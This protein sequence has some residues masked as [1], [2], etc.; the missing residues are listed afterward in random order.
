M[1]CCSRLCFCQNDPPLL[2]GPKDPVLPSLM[3]LNPTQYGL[4]EVC[5]VYNEG[6]FGYLYPMLGSVL[7]VLCGVYLLIH[8]NH[9]LTY[10]DDRSWCLLLA[11]VE[12]QNVPYALTDKGCLI[13]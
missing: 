11:L 10:E 12:A 5:T 3:Y 6:S 4:A 13:F 1:V 7:T 2:Q 9:R 8:F